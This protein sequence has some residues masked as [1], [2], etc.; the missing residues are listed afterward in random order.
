MESRTL[1]VKGSS[2][3]GFR[4]TFFE[5]GINTSNSIKLQNEV[6]VTKQHFFG[7]WVLMSG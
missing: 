6:I 2:E 3:F 7:V 4:Q 1:I 5:F